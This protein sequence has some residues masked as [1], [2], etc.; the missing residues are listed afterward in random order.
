[1]MVTDINNV[2][3]SVN[4]SFYEYYRVISREEAVGQTP[5][6]LQSDRHDADFYKAM[7]T[8]VEATGSWQG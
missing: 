6:L 4:K 5:R 2:I 3:V 1:M 8:S 7:W